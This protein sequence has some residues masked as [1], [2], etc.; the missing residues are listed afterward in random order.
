M[1]IYRETTTVYYML[2]KRAKGDKRGTLGCTPIAPPFMDQKRTSF[3]PCNGM[4][5]YTVHVPTSLHTIWY[6]GMYGYVVL[7]V[8]VYYYY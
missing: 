5:V 7:H 2:S 4:L 8:V 3:R 6:I 1:Y